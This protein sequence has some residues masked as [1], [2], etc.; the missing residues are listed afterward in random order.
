[1][2]WASLL[3]GFAGVILILKPGRALLSDPIALIAIGAAVFSALA[4]VAVNRLAV[5]RTAA[6][7]LVGVCFSPDVGPDQGSGGRRRPPHRE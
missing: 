2:V 5:S 3:I 6:D 1:M 4:L 7:A